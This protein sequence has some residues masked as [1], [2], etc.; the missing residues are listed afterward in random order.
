MT[1]FRSSI[2]SIRAEWRYRSCVRSAIEIPLPCRPATIVSPHPDDETIAL[3]GLIARKRKAGIPVRIVLITRGEA[4]HRHCCGADPD[5][6]AGLRLDQFF[7]ATGHLGVTRENIHVLDVPDGGIPCPVDPGFEDLSNRI[8]ALIPVGEASEIYCPHP[9]DGL[10]D[11]ERTA[12]LIEKIVLN[13]NEPFQIHHY[14]VWRWILAPTEKTSKKNQFLAGKLDIAPVA[15]IK[16]R[17]LDCYLDTPAPCGY[18]AGGILPPVILR[19][20]REP[21]EFVFMHVSPDRNQLRTKR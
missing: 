3:G 17:A 13:R 8:S 11:H 9:R 10:P 20:A 1:S 6:I 15:D 5:L 7:R 4:S 12:G 16:K 21:R 18:P 14:P 2:K 19:F